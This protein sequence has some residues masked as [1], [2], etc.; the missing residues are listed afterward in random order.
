MASASSLT[1]QRDRSATVM[2][3]LGSV[4]IPGSVHEKAL[5]EVAVAKDVVLNI[6]NLRL[7]P[8]QAEDVVCMAAL[9]KM[10]RWGDLMTNVGILAEPPGSGKMI[11]M[12]AHVARAP[13]PDPTNPFVSTYDEIKMANSGFGKRI[14]GQHSI[15]VGGVEEQYVPAAYFPLSVVVATPATSHAWAEAM[16]VHGGLRVFRISTHAEL[17]EFDQQRDSL[18]GTCDVIVVSKSFV[19]GLANRLSFMRVSRLILDD[20]MD[21]R[22]TSFDIKSCF[23]WLIEP[24]ITPMI[25]WGHSVPSC[26]RK[27]LANLCLPSAK[28]PTPLFVMHSREEVDH[29]LGL[30]YPVHH[31]YHLSVPFFWDVT[32]I[33]TPKPEDLA[34]QL[35]ARH[36]MPVWGREA[37]ASMVNP[38]V[39]DRVEADL[40]SEEGCMICLEAFGDHGQ[41]LLTCCTR[42]LCCSCVWKILHTT[43]VCPT[44][45]SSIGNRDASMVMISDRLDAPPLNVSHFFC[46]QFQRREV[47]LFILSRIG[48][49]GRVLIYTDCIDHVDDETGLEMAELLQFQLNL[50]IVRFTGSGVQQRRKLVDYQGIGATAIPNQLGRIGSVLNPHEM[51][52]GVNLDATT[53]IIFYSPPNEKQYEHVLSRVVNARTTTAIRRGGRRL[54]V[55]ILA[56]NEA[57]LPKFKAAYEGVGAGRGLDTKLY[58]TSIAQDLVIL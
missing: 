12:V 45:R 26:V 11:T 6:G 47:L 7:F 27:A 44:C 57:L 37:A 39:R 4:H 31:V 1:C 41:C 32:T 53:D 35:V 20:A 16:E 55:H 8:H 14:D 50:R 9:E 46:P 38:A 25:S 56:E 3:S 24:D 19:Q 2:Q 49:G 52:R 58:E 29:S 17:R 28:D 21:L 30:E 13:L 40:R 33:P 51:A 18:P 5:N 43:R 15:W 22:G 23:L 10:E 48:V 36:S 34:K 54:A 42:M